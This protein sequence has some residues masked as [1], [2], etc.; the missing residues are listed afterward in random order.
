[1]RYKGYEIDIQQ[2]IN[3]ENPRNWDNLG[4]MVCFHRRY[5]LGDKHKFTGPDSLQDFL[6]KEKPPVLLPL[7]L[8]D[9]GNISIHTESVV[10]KAPH[11]E[12][13]SG[14]IGYTYVTRAALLKEYGAKRITAKMLAQATKI[15]QAEVKTYDQYLNGEVY[16]YTI[17]DVDG[18]LVDSCGGYFGEKE[19]IAEA[20]R[21][22]DNRPEY[23][24]AY[25]GPI[26]YED[27][28]W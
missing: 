23:V 27:Q 13:D 20:K 25:N 11:A 14:K 17:E 28:G 4:I 2:D 18:T 5:D 10:G 19:A 24:Q 7:Y 15:L 9:H 6:I 3:P 26:T 16:D 22:I 12:W 1:M 21:I 8:Y